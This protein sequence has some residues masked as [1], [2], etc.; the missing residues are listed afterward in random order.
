M[1]DFTSGICR[2]AIERLRR[3]SPRRIQ[4][5]IGSPAMSP[6]IATGLPS[7]FAALDGL[8]ERP[9]DGRVQRV[10]EVADVLVLAVG[11]QRVL[12]EVVGADAEEVALRRQ[13]VGDERRARASRP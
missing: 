7:L 11:G 2:G 8:L 9:Q 4:A 5:S 6:H 13:Q 12:D 1:I 3:P 10:V